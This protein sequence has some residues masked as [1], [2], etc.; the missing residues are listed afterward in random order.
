MRPAD[1]PPE[2]V[3]MEEEDSIRLNRGEFEAVRCLLGA[4]NYAAH[5]NDDL[6]KRLMIIGRE[7]RM[8]DVLQELRDVTDDVIGSVPV[9]QCRQLKNTMHD[10]EIRMTPKLAPMS[11]NIVLDKDIA[12]DLIDIAIEKCRGCVEDEK[13]C[14]KCALY[15]VL[16]SFLPMEDY[17]NSLL[18]PYSRAEWE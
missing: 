18:C 16:E 12:K 10:M 8:A 13:E 6:R 2:R 15:R 17:E 11:R 9:G 3:W 1:L 7:Q 5:A 4:V 14:R